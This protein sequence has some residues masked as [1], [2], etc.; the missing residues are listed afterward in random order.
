[1]NT[2]QFYVIFAGH[3]LE[4]FG[5]GNLIYSLEMFIGP[6]KG[7]PDQNNI[8][9]CGSHVTENNHLSIMN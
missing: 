4:I 3:T 7:E 8:E 1:M 2:K 9:K 5:I 6:L